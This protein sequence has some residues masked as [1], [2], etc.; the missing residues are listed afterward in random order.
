[1]KLA[2]ASCMYLRHFPQQPVWQ[3]VVRERPDVL[4]LLGDSIYM[5]F[6]PELKKSQAISVDDFALQMG[7]AYAQQYAV[8]KSSGVLDQVAG[9]VYATWDDHDFAWNNAAGGDAEFAAGDGLRKKRVSTALFHEFRAALRARPASYPAARTTAALE[10][11][12]AAAGV[13]YESV[14]LVPG[15]LYLHMTDG[16]SYR[17]TAKDALLGAAQLGWLAGRVNQ[18]GQQANAVHLIGLGTT[19]DVGKE[20]AQLYAQEWAALQALCAPRKAV[21]L[22]GDVHE[23]NFKPHGLAGGK[24]VYELTSSGAAIRKYE[25]FGKRE[26]FATLTALPGEIRVELFGLKVSDFYAVNRSTWQG[27]S[28]AAVGPATEI[29]A[30]GWQADLYRGG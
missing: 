27:A 1:M 24:T 16:R 26:N 10:A 30:H 4:V 15:E 25:Y 21:F 7:Q 18:A 29:T 14:E 19:L 9:K 6:F 13:V 28:A 17:T 2:I 20:A 11:A 8:L 3:A 12:G 23:N 5:D 22:T